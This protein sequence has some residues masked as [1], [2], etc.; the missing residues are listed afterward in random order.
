MN[1]YPEGNRVRCRFAFL[2]RPLTPAESKAFIETGALP[3]GIGEVPAEAFLDFQPPGQPSKTL[4][5]ADVISDGGGEFHSILTGD[6]TGVW[7][8]RGRGLDAEG[9]PLA[10]TPDVAFRITRTF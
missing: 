3:G 8:Y 2:T 9:N 5:G 4:E 1:S 7:S 10:A 6:K